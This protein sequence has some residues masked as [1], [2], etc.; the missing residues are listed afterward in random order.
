LLSYGSESISRESAVRFIIVDAE[1][2]LRVFLATLLRTLA[3][4]DVGGGTAE[5]GPD[6]CPPSV[7]HYAIRKPPF[8]RISARFFIQRWLGTRQAASL[9]VFVNGCRHLGPATDF[10]NM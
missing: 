3:D 4:I 1:R 6:L 9:C 2:P 7:A 10:A 5:D 8:I